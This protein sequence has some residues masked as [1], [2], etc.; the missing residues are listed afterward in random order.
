[1]DHLPVL[2]VKECLN[3]P[4]LLYYV[5]FVYPWDGP[6]KIPESF[7]VD[8]ISKPKTFHGTFVS[9][10]KVGNRTSL[11]HLLFRWLGSFG[12]EVSDYLPRT[13]AWYTIHV[14]IPDPMFLLFTHSV[15]FTSVLKICTNKKRSLRVYE[16]IVLPDKV[17]FYFVFHGFQHQFWVFVLKEKHISFQNICTIFISMM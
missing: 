15:S 14:M 6:Y 10:Q 3:N 1:M 7:I 12:K 16:D 4:D 17:L 13:C 9:V 2:W 5:H 11:V 8:P